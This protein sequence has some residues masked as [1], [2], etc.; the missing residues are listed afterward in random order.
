MSL[1]NPKRVRLLAK[2]RP[3]PGAVIVGASLSL[4]GSL[5]VR[6]WARGIPRDEKPASVPSFVPAATPIT[7]G[8]WAYGLRVPFDGPSF[9]PAKNTVILWSCAF[10]AA[11]IRGSSGL[12][13]P[14]PIGPYE[15]VTTRIL[16][17][18]WCDR[19]YSHPASA[20]STTMTAPPPE[21]T[22]L[23]PGATPA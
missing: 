17:R 20:L 5:S 18:S 12:N 23:T 21:P 2:A 15:L 4:E 11:I 7:H 10:F 1:V 3:V 13:A 19:P 22:I 6:R 14:P 9:P 8:A 16:Y